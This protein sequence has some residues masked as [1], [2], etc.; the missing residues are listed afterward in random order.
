MRIA[1][2]VDLCEEQV[3]RATRLAARLREE[4]MSDVEEHQA[5]VRALR[6]RDADR[7]SM[8]A[9]QHREHVRDDILARLS[10]LNGIVASY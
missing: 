4:V 6:D 2:S 9:M 7:A 8:L 1:N 5:I 10:R 3:G